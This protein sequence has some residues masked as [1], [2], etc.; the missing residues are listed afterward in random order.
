MGGSCRMTAIVGGVFLRVAVRSPAYVLFTL[1]SAAA[2]VAATIPV[3]PG[4]VAGESHYLGAG[5]STLLLGGV[6]LS[7]VLLPGMHAASRGRWNEETLLALPVDREILAIGAFV[8]FG[9]ALCVFCAICGGAYVVTAERAFSAV[10]VGDLFLS[11]VF[12][13]LL[14][15]VVAAMVTAFGVI[16]APLPA[17]IVAVVFILAGQAAGF[18]P[19]VISFVLPPFDLLDPGRAVSGPFTESA[20][21]GAG[22]AL[23]HGFACLAF[24]LCVA[25]VLLRARRTGSAPL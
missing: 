25:I 9:A 5:A 3:S 13:L 15:L 7:L 4:I 16:L 24:Y 11:T 2:V 19:P 10:A 17:L 21:L 8:G 22:R 6:L 20:A 23:G 12:C 1:A 14:S 18:W